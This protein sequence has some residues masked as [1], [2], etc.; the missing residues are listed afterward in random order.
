MVE[1]LQRLFSAPLFEDE[2]KTHQAYLL[3][4]IL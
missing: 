1:K 2:E 3:N 4:F